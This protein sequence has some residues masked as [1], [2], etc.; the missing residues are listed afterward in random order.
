M[1]ALQTP[2]LEVSNHAR[3]DTNGQFPRRRA[4]INAL[5]VAP[6]TS[7]RPTIRA[8]STGTSVAVGMSATSHLAVIIKRGCF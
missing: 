4:L 3:M 8:S 2:K 6:A 1:P 7:T 5:I